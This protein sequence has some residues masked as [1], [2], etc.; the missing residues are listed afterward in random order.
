MS[1]ILSGLLK[2]AFRGNQAAREYPKCQ[3]WKSIPLEKGNHHSSVSRC[4]S[5]SNMLCLSSHHFS[6]PGNQKAH[7]TNAQ[8][9]LAA[10]MTEFS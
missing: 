5:L 7:F 3:P 10:S 8:D 9:K 2:F 4:H 1:A 6:Q